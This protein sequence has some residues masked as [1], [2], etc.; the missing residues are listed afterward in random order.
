MNKIIF[1]V[2]LLAFCVSAVVYSIQDMSFLDVIARS[3][4]IFMVTIGA[5]I[6]IVFVTSTFTAK[7]KG[8]EDSNTHPKPTI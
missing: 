6:G 7:E 2:G 8:L 1:Q 3:F 5:L 4:I